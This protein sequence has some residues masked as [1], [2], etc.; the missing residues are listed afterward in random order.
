M[1]KPPTVHPEP[2][3]TP[4]RSKWDKYDADV[5]LLKLD[6]KE[7]VEKLQT[8]RKRNMNSN[9]LSVGISDT[10]NFKDRVRTVKE[11]VDSMTKCK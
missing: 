8:Q 10:P 6:N 5:E 9:N 3:A 7:K 1:P 4:L 2:L 11:Y